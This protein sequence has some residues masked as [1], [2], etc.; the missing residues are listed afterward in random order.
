MLQYSTLLTRNKRAGKRARLALDQCRRFQM[1]LLFFA[2]RPGET[3]G[4]EYNVRVQCTC[5]MYN[6]FGN[7]IPSRTCNVRLILSA[8]FR[9]KYL[10]P[11]SL[12]VMFVN[13]PMQQFVPNFAGIYSKRKA[14]AF[15]PKCDLRFT[16]FKEKH[17]GSNYNRLST[18]S[19]Y[20]SKS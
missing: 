3:F 8:F 13:C 17:N 4:F 11:I 7:A 12:N 18:I 20:L 10:E 19:H 14:L 9:D 1:S 5:T 2:V 16:A 6:V 15:D